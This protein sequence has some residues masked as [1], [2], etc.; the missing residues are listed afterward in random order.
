MVLFLGQQQLFHLNQTPNWAD[1]S[2]SLNNK[3]LKPFFSNKITYRG[4]FKSGPMV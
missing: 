3:W 4:G 1:K 2:G